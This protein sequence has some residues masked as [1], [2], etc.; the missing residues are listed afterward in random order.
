MSIDTA[1]QNGREKEKRPSGPLF[2]KRNY[3]LGIFNG[4][5][6]SFGRQFISARIVLSEFIY[7]F[8]HSSTLVGLTVALNS[9]TMIW[10]QLF[11]SNLV[12]HRARKKP[13]YAFSCLVRIITIAF[14]FLLLARSGSK[15]RSYFFPL[16][17]LLYFIFGIGTG[18]GIIPF[19][20]I[21]SRTIPPTKRGSF[22]GNRR[23]WSGLL[24][25]PFALF[26]VHRVVRWPFPQN[27]LTLFAVSSFWVVM[28]LI[29]FLFV[30]EPPGIPRAR[31][32]RFKYHLASGFR[33]LRRNKNCRNLLLMRF[34]ATIGDLPMAFYIPYAIK[35]LGLVKVSGIFL[36]FFTLSRVL[37]SL[38]W[39]KMG[40]RKGNKF[41]LAMNAILVTIAPLIA[42]AAGSLSKVVHIG[43]WEAN[44]GEVV[45]IMALMIS[46]T[47]FS[48]RSI[49]QVNFLLEMA[50]ER[51]RPSFIAFMNTFAFPLAFFPLLGGI[52]A[53]AFG[54]NLLFFI[55]FLSGM[56]MLY[57][58][59]R[60][61]EVRKT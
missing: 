19:Y 5:S 28:G 3:Y 44:V 7:E 12:E 22:F 36:A 32:L 16:F 53:D 37:P 20:D 11:V 39:G 56:A 29:I 24:M 31:R 50:P 49:A 59:L 26:F 23:F 8:T 51:R 58:V 2:I 55:S 15:P 35:I 4:V 13:F 52:F 45:L 6:Y 42:I 54:F 21:I 33:T 18:I 61:E 60:L 27:Y 38:F 57:F 10:P 48:G 25:F 40:D 14:I 17:F 30:T 41:V 46:G 43:G 47:T 34:F 1:R 9:A